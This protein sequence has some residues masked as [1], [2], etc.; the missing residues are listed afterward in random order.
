MIMEKVKTRTAE[1]WKDERDILWVK[2]LEGALIDREDAADNIL[3]I[4]NLS[5]NKPVLRMLDSRNNWGITPEGET[6]SQAAFKQ[7][8]TI[9]HAVIVSSLADKILKNFILQFNRPNVPLKA[10]TSEA[11]AL[12]W[13]LSLKK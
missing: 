9:A 8:N 3:V 2:V 11:D 10:F 5:E 12:S 1:I 4:R 6:Y 7:S 13:L